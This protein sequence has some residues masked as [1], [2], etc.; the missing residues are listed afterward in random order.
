MYK[1]SYNKDKDNNN[2]KSKLSQIAT[3]LPGMHQS[4]SGW[5]RYFWLASMDLWM[6]TMHKRGALAL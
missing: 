3:L 6:V 1:A 2:N 5:L 4:T